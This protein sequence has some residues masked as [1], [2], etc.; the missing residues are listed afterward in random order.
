MAPR[1][2]R[3]TFE[4]PGDHA[5][6]METSLLLYLAPQLVELAEA[7]RGE[8]V[9]FAID[10]LVQ[11]GVWTPRPWSKCHPDAGSGDPSRATAA[12]GARYFTAVVEALATLLVGLSNAKKGQLPYV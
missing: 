8:R 6:E 10:G 1:A 12:K 7:G 11:P 3:E 4:A 2:L 5:D 9:P